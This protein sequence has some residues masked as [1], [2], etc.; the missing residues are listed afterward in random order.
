[1]AEAYD[2]DGNLRG[3]QSFVPWGN[4]GLSLDLMRRDSGA[5]N[6][7]NEFIVA[8][9]IASA[10]D[11]GIRR[12]SLNFAMFRAVFEEGE[13]I[14]AGPV[15]RLWRSILTFFSRFFQLES[16]Y[17]SNA[18]YAPDWAPR[19]LCYQSSR[20]LPRVAVVAGMAEGFLPSR[21]RARATQQHPMSAEFLTRVAEIDRAAE[22][23]C[24][25]QRRVPEQVRVRLDKADHFGDDAY[26]PAPPRTCVLGAIRDEFGDLAPDTRTGKTV[27]VAGRI[28]AKREHGGL[29]FAAVR[30]FSGQ[31]QVM[32][33]A[34]RLGAGELADWRSRI[35]IGDQ[36]SV[37]GEVVT[38]RHGE[39]SVDANSWQL[40]AKC[41]HPLPDKRKG[42]TDIEARTRQR[43]LD[44]MINPSAADMLKLRNTVLRSI[45]EVL[46]GQEFLEV[47]T[48]M[49]QNVHGGANA[50]PFLTHI[51]A[52]DMRMYLRIAP[53]LYL[54]RL[55]VAGVDRLFELNRNFRNEGA[56]S[57][58]NPEFT[59]LEA[60]Q[61]YADYDVMRD[62][63]TDLI[64]RAATNVYGRP[65]AH[66]VDADGEVSEVDI[67]GPWQEISVYRAVSD[68]LGAEIDPGTDAEK[69]RELCAAQ[70]I[71]AAG[72]L[73][74]ANLV[75][76]VYDRL[77]EPDTVRP[78]FYRDFPAAVSPLTRQHRADGRL[79][80]RWDLVAFGSEIGT[81]YTELTD[82]RIQRDRLTAQSFKA[83]RG[84][85]EAME[86]DEE[87]LR[88]LEYGMPPTGGLG[89]GV[90]RVIMM[91]TGAPI[92]QTITFPF[93]R[94]SGR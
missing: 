26:P 59:M 8:D 63:V 72:D 55:C 33:S 4:S 94:Q 37:T 16:L 38:S 83:A 86:L 93:V 48:P 24:Q 51:N 80:E 3:L 85:A 67:S 25:S 44:L 36:L 28:M 76:H 22:V 87:F 23:P 17:R 54:K 18:K 77:V 84:D 60:Y 74:H 65:V 45:R 49:L 34:D 47:E 82:P 66:R 41:L 70:D 32:L 1:M 39:L 10:Q 5:V 88:A 69:L 81:G 79:A 35:D 43:Y 2:A 46:Q 64:V 56:D 15:L 50:R 71:P 14:G 52:Y 29:C 40:T 62:L 19:F 57:S 78:T 27:T 58:H 91:L 12:I 75:L 90:D 30:D 21:R 6:G 73:D 53:E 89:M 20:Q 11:L 42:F 13:R 7:I 92:R 9:V 31:L 68:A 61:A